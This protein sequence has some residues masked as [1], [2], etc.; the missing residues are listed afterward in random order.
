MAP[1]ISALRQIIP[2]W[3]CASHQEH[4]HNEGNSIYAGIHWQ[5]HTIFWYLAILNGFRKAHCKSPLNA[6]I[7]T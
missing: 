7:S 6:S 5:F 3:Q 1:S 2:A 4:Q